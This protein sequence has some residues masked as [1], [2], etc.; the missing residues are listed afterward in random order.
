MNEQTTIISNV[1][2]VSVQHYADLL[3]MPPAT[4]M[5]RLTKHKVPVMRFGK[6]YSQRIISLDVMTEAFRAMRS[7]SI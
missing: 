4:L 1:G 2:M 6:K 3:G 7:E 5:Q